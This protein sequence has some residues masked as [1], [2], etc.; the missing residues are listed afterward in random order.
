[1]ETK[2]E[3]GGICISGRIYDMIENKL[4][5]EFAFIGEHLVKNI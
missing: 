2:A 5:L 3:A 4:E 1:V